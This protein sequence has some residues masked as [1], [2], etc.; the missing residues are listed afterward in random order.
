ML[1]ATHIATRVSRRRRVTRGSSP[2]VSQS[3]I[4]QHGATSRRHWNRAWIYRGRKSTR[5]PVAVRTSGAT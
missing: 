1:C 3:D 4:G 5:M 2:A